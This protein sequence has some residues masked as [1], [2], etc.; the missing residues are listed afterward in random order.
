MKLNIEF[1]KNNVIAIIVGVVILGAIGVSAATSLYTPTQNL[2]ET[3]PTATIAPTIEPTL[4]PTLNVTPEPTQAVITLDGVTINA[5]NSIINAKDSTIN[6]T[7]TQ[8]PNPPVVT[9]SP[10][11]TDTPVVWVDLRSSYDGMYPVIIDGISYIRWD[12]LQNKCDAKNIKVE[13]VVDFENRT[14]YAI[15]PN[16]PVKNRKHGFLLY[17]TIDG[18][19]RQLLK[20]ET[21]QITPDYYDIFSVTY[22]TYLDVIK[23]VLDNN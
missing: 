3:T 18:E 21:V 5:I 10:A 9:N 8:A 22:Q 23:P 1:V 11:V 15:D 12:Q 4:A 17:K 13:C 16:D 14:I 2:I 20:V 7:V 19:P 6:A